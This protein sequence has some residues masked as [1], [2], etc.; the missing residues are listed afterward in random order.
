MKD[1][2]TILFDLDGC[3]TD[4]GPSIVKSLLYTIEEMGKTPPSE[5]SLLKYVGPPLHDNMVRLFGNEKADEAVGLFRHAF[6]NLG[7]G[8]QYTTQ[9]AGIAEILSVLR[10][11]GKDLFIA[12][13]KGEDSAKIVLEHLSLLP[14]FKAVHGG[15]ANGIDKGELISHVVKSYKLLP[16]TTIMIGDRSHDII[17]AKENGLRSVG[18]LWGYGSRQELE[19]AEADATVMTPHELVKLL[20]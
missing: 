8:V 13:S 5:Q 11:S 15:G 4:S 14:F 17:G 16:S 1:V 10:A 7:Y 18:V 20:V 3:L 2:K 6:Q 12:T 9:Y 19:E